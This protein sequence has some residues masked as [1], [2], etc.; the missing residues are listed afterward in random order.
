MLPASRLCVSSGLFPSASAG[1][2][3][4]SLSSHPDYQ[5]TLLQ[6]F[7]TLCSLEWQMQPH[8]EN[9]LSKQITITEIN[10]M[11]MRV[12]LRYLQLNCV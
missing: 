2:N 7:H 5:S 9:R 4:K 10:R 8:S 11:A 3:K 1:R 6:H 12:K